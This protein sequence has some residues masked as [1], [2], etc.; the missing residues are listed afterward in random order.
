[1]LTSQGAKL[2]DFGLAKE[3]EPQRGLASTATFEQHPFT[4]EGS[5]IGTFQYMAPEQLEGRPVDA[6]TDLFAFGVLLYEMATGRKAFEGDSQASLIASI[7][8]STPPPVSAARNTLEALPPALDHIVERCLEKKPADRWQ[9]ARDLRLELEWSARGG[10]STPSNV[11]VPGERSRVREA[12]AWVLAAAAVAAVAVITLSNQ[13]PKAVETN[14]F[15]IATPPGTT[16][17]VPV[18]RPRLAIS[19]NGRH[20]A[21]IGTTEGLQQ[22]WVRSL[23]S[24]EARVL[25]GTD[26][27]FSPFWSPDSRFIGFFVV[28]SGELR[29]VELSGGPARTIAGTLD[30]GARI[31]SDGS[32]VWGPDG[33]IVF[34]QF[35]DGLYRVA[36]DGGVAARVTRRDTSKGEMNHYWPSFLPDGRRFL[37]LATALDGSGARV[38]PTIYVGS[39]DAPMKVPVGQ[40]HSKVL[41]VPATSQLL[42]VENGVLMAQHFDLDALRRSGDPQPVASDVA[43]YKALGSAGFGVSETGVLAYHGAEDRQQL[44]WYDRQGIATDT[45]WAPQNFGAFRV[46]PDGRT[47]A[48]GI[49]DPVSGASDIWSYDIVRG[50][51]VRLTSEGFANA[52]VWA[53]DGR[54]FAFATGRSGAPK[55]VARSVDGVE[56]ELLDVKSPVTPEDWAPDGRSL[57]YTDSNRTRGQDL[58]VLSV[59]G[60]RTHRTLTAGAAIERAARVSPDSAWVAFVSDESGTAEVYVV[61]IGGGEK[62]RI[63]VGGG[64]SPHWRRDGRELLYAAADKRSIMSVAVTPGRTFGASVPRRLFTMRAEVSSRIGLRSTGFDMLPDAD[65]FLMAVPTGDATSSRITIVQNWAAALR[66]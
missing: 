66:K 59:A 17:G 1:M 62:T 61:P 47:L 43:Y 15:T 5:I 16:V 27:A 46:S 39:L 20:V 60:T 21:F 63:S 18:N 29:R 31:E 25:P 65:R 48:V 9:T 32:P 13:Q 3:L 22:L 30:T 11:P 64:F 19:P 14:R 57:L 10:A 24:L 51:P 4:V 42:F 50:A 28:G 41:F 53:P 26:N 58:G 35:R 6:R 52:P 7:L 55:I 2:L 8:R 44:V 40:L 12:I 37:Y 38:P 49:E 34:T 45:G 54:R 23:D 33:T 36:S 56:E